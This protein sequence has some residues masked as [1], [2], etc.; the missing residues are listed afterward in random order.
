MDPVPGAYILWKEKLQQI[1]LKVI[2]NLCPPQAFVLQESSPYI[3][4]CQDSLC[5]QLVFAGLAA[6]PEHVHLLSQAT[7]QGC[8][9]KHRQEAGLGVRTGFVLVVTP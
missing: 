9:Q 8:G 4:W 6:E 2:S 3:S 7:G 5:P 1:L